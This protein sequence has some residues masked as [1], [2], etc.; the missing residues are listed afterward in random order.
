MQSPKFECIV[1]ISC[2]FLGTLNTKTVKFTAIQIEKMIFFSYIL[3]NETKR[4]DMIFNE[5]DGVL[6]YIWRKCSQIVACGI[7]K[8]WKDDDDDAGRRP[9][10]K[11]KKPFFK[12]YDPKKLV[13][14]QKTKKKTEAIAKKQWKKN[15]KRR[16]QVP[17][18]FLIK[19][20]K[21]MK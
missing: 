21:K 11:R 2:R 13:P 9:N 4:N 12:G 20:E 3:R 7:E 8:A 5:D 10:D 14:N 17:I 6:R 15:K 16:I 1:D 19:I 18:H